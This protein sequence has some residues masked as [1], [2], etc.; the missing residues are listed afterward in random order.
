MEPQDTFWWRLVHLD[1]AIYRGIIMA[2]VGLLASLGIL[3]SDAIPNAMIIVIGT[4]VVAVQ[5]LWTR[6]GVTPNA[7]VVVYVDDPN[8]P[9]NV[10]PGEAVTTASDKAILEAANTS[11]G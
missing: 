3:V 10:L 6:T 1:P 11:G 4:L 2:V 5:A 7:K 9:K 8:R